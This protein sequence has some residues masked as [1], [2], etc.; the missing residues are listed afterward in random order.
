MAQERVPMSKFKS[1]PSFLTEIRVPNLL[2]LLQKAV[3]Y[4]FTITEELMFSMLDTV[5]AVLKTKVNEPP[6]LSVLINAS[7]DINNHKCL[8]LY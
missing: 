7:T 8:I 3:A 5:H 4:S 2:S 6:L 1:L